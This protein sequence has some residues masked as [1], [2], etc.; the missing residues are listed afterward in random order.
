[1]VFEIVLRAHHIEMRVPIWGTE[2]EEENQEAYA[3]S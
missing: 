2:L 1:M 3:L